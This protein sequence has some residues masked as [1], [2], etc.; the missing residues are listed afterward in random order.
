[1]TS[2]MF[3]NCDWLQQIYHYSSQ[4]QYEDAASYEADDTGDKDDADARIRSLS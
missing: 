1:M 3:A 4:N 2:G